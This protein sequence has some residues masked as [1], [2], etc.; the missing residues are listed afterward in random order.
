MA[1]LK[2]DNDGNMLGKMV[3]PFGSQFGK[4]YGGWASQTAS[5]WDSGWVDFNK[6]DALG[7]DGRA[8]TM[9]PGRPNLIDIIDIPNGAL[10][11]PGVQIFTYMKGNHDGIFLWVFSTGLASGESI[12]S[13]PWPAN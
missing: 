2:V 10:S 11:V 4:N 8:N 1:Y 6:V 9:V 12:C 13:A 3:V 5:G 7:L